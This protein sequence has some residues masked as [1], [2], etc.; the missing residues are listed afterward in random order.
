MAFAHGVVGAHFNRLGI[1]RVKRLVERNIFR[2]VHHHRARAAA[3]GDVESLFHDIGHVFGIFDQEVVLNDRAGNAHGI[4]LLKRIQTDGR[5]G[6]LP[7]DDDH[8]DAVHVG[9][10][11]TG[12]GVGQTGAR[13]DQR[14]AHFACGTGKTVGRMHSGLLMAHQNV[15]N[16]VLLVESIVDVQN[17]T[18]GV[19]PDVL[20]GFSLKRFDEDFCTAQF[21]SARRCRCRFG[22]VHFHIQPL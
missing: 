10:R 2:N 8:R 12:H 19:S 16:G 4:A 6:H 17:G 3:A 1:A 18:T 14:H 22:F 20:H 15:L 5:S 13:S 11:N 7:A 21:L 9:R